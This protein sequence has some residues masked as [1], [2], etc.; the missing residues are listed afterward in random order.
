MS[1]KAAKQKA[2]KEKVVDKRTDNFSTFANRDEINMRVLKRVV[3]E[4]IQKIELVV[5]EVSL[6]RNSESE[7]EWER[8]LV[9]GPLF[10]LRLLENP[11]P[12]VFVM[13]NTCFQNT[14]NFTKKIVVAKTTM[15]VIE[16]KL[17]LKFEDDS[18]MAFSTKDATLI[19][20]LYEGLQRFDAH[21]EK[22]P[23]IP[24]SVK[25][26]PTYQHIMRVWRSQTRV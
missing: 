20:Q 17:Y 23:E 6:Y 13:N 14:E 3:S 5:P 21:E 11:N 16:N 15:K 10:L 25:S 9:S 18:M 12:F 7:N 22:P 19:R 4:R 1:K 2:A 26:D 24:D 8:L